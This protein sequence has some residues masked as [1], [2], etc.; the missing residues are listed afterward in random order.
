MTFIKVNCGNDMYEPVMFLI[1]GSFAS[2][3]FT[4]STLRMLKKFLGNKTRS[5]LY[6]TFMYLFFGIY[7]FTQTI[8]MII[9]GFLGFNLVNISL[10]CLIIAGFFVVLSVNSISRAD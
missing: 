3:F 9:R 8:G 7:A 5:S 2:G 1:F 6:M 10:V 4:I